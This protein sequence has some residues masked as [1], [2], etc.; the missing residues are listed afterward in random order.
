MKYL[1]HGSSIYVSLIVSIY[2][3]SCF[4]GMKE[5]CNFDLVQSSLLK[6]TNS[7]KTDFLECV[8]R[9][10]DYHSSSELIKISKLICANF[11]KRS[12][13]DLMS[14]DI[15]RLY[16][17]ANSPEA[18]Y[19][20]MSKPGTK[21]YVIEDKDMILGVVI[22]RPNQIGGK[23]ND[24]Q[25]RRLHVNFEAINYKKIGTVLLTIAAVDAFLNNIATLITT[26]SMPARGFFEKL[27][28]DGQVIESQYCIEKKGVVLPQ[29]KCA[30]AIP[31]D[32]QGF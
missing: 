17:Q 4:A 31:I 14:D 26:A 16:L 7:S 3:I 30:Y 2:S 18:L 1:I 29:F 15:I 9:P 12:G 10:F 25:V 8:A 22:L 5:V 21:G 6:I 27:G 32:F 13:W 28:W 23:V 24:L 20:T 19:E 11:V